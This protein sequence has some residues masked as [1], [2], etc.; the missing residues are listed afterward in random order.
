VTENSDV[1]NW[2]NEYMI[3]F[4]QHKIER[5]RVM[6][7][8][9]VRMRHRYWMMCG[10]H[11]FHPV[12]GRYGFDSLPPPV[13][14]EGQS[15]PPL[16]TLKAMLKREND[17]RL[18]PEV[19]AKFADPSFDAISI[20][21]EVQERVVCEYG[22]CGSKQQI[23]LGLDIIRS[24]PLLYPDEPELRTIPHYV[25]YNRSRR[26]ELDAGDEIPN[27]Y[28]AHLSGAPV[29]LFDCL[30][31]LASELKSRQQKNRVTDAANDLT[32]VNEPNTHQ[33]DSIE[34]KDAEDTVVIACGSY[35]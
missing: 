32:R 22:Y 18:S 4:S 8:H 35:T 31:S 28:L 34:N 23:K 29:T 9:Q 27:S 1:Q 15:K 17:L 33:T 3:R 5:Q 16:E 25:K 20:A 26:G 11:M 21:S 12:N 6:D 14:P 19:Q 2:K 30:D 10:V 13:F 24:A 7:L